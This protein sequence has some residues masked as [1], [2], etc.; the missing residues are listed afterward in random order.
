MSKLLSE[1]IEDI[2]EYS[3]FR[4]K[5]RYVSSKT[6]ANQFEKDIFIP[7]H[8]I[9]QHVAKYQSIRVGQRPS[10]NWATI[11]IIDSSID[12]TTNKVLILRMTNMRSNHYHIFLIGKAYE[13]CK[14]KLKVGTVF[15]IIKPTILRPTNVGATVGLSAKHLNQICIIGESMD[16]CRC[17]GYLLK[18]KQCTI[19]IDRRSGEYCDTHIAS[20]CNFSKNSRMELASG[21]SGMDIRWTTTSTSKHGQTVYKSVSDGKTAYDQ[22]N[23]EYSYVIP[24]ICTMTSDGKELN[25][26][27]VVDQQKLAKEKNAWTKFLKGRNDPGAE[28]I[29]K[30]KGIKEEENNTV[31][32][33]EA[34]L[35][36][37]NTILMDD[38][39]KANKRKAVD[40]ILKLRKK[41]K[42]GE[43]DDKKYIY[44]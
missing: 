36:I 10:G 11:G 42:D 17:K 13:D 37:H 16:I 30:I 19:M 31:L 21:D 6:L 40:E 41:I 14:E 2:E 12:N 8:Q 43:E 15:S 24:D 9:N 34:N 33:K 3:G 32:S 35:R 7:C 22:I 38:K 18:N 44:L 4:L 25:K 20:I 1:N 5:E 27:P 29:R 23:K 39:D 26:K 28:M